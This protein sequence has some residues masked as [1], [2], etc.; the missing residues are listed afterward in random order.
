MKIK[1]NHFHGRE[2][3]L[4][5]LLSALAAQ[6]GNDGDEGNAMQGAYDLLHQIYAIAKAA[7]EV[8]MANYTAQEVAKLNQGMA[9]IVL[10]LKPAL[11][12]AP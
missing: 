11:E 6:E 7:P 10:L 8:N 3:P 9:D 2:V 12:V 1:A 4:G 5:S